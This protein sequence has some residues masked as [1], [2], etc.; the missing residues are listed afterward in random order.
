MKGEEF[1]TGRAW[2]RTAL[3]LLILLVGVLASGCLH[4]KASL[5][6]SGD[7]TVSGEVL[8]S[9]QTPD[10]QVPFQL[11]PPAD[12]SD[13]VRVTPYSKDGRVGSQLSFKEL[14]FEETERL[15]TSL[16]PGNA[17]YQFKL[18]RSGSLV[19]FT[20]SV[21]LTPLDETD[22]SVLIELSTPGETTTTNGRET[23]GMVSWAPEPGQVTQLSAAFQFTSSSTPSWV[24]WALLVGVLAFGAAGLVGYLAQRSN[25]QY[26][27]PV[28]QEE[29]ANADS[30]G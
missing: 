13:K 4:T 9:T 11:R 1:R 21:D 23:A 7:D 10:G 26:H 19:L 17:R 8:L 18:Q 15:A 6:I 16:S 24:W 20:G 12:L 22:S 2:F 30:V 3:A 27:H 5:N 28:Q 25:E 29:P 14:T